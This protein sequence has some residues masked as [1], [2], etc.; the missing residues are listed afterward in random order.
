MA[1]L[2]C[3]RTRAPACARWRE[4]RHLIYRASHTQLA[5]WRVKRKLIYNLT[6]RAWETSSHLPQSLLKAGELSR[7]EL[8]QGELSQSRSDAKAG[9]Y[10]DAIAEWLSRNLNLADVSSVEMSPTEI[11][12]TK[13]ASAW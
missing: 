13:I 7:D 11:S 9:L 2:A 12:S 1:L 6:Y 8:S 4:E 5:S 10:L 3:L